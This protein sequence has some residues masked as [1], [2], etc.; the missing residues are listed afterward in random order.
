MMGLYTRSIT[1]LFQQNTANV[2]FDPYRANP[3]DYRSVSSKIAI[4]SA[5]SICEYEPYPRMRIMEL[6]RELL[7]KLNY[8]VPGHFG[9]KLCEEN[10]ITQIMRT[11]HETECVFALEKKLEVDFIEELI[12]KLRTD[13]AK[14]DGIID[15]MNRTDG[16]SV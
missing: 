6:G 4:S 2:A 13:V 7:D 10:T 3:L 9:F 12:E 11:T 14:L 15:R 16:T 5:F 1:P 8:E